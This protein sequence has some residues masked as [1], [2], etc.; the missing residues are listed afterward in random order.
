MVGKVSRKGHP[1][2]VDL[3]P[4]RIT[5]F[6]DGYWPVMMEAREARKTETDNTPVKPTPVLANRS[7]LGVLI[8]DGLVCRGYS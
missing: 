7:R 2:G 1:V 6:T 3:P 4:L 5:P 8:P